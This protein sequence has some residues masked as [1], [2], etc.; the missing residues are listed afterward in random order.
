M[1]KMRNVYIISAKYEFKTRE[2]VGHLYVCGR[3]ILK[4]PLKTK[5]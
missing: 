1:N 4:M 3:I 5:I 2:D